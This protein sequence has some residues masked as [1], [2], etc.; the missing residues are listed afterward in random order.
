MMGYSETQKGMRCYNPDN[1]IVTISRDVT[2]VDEPETYND[3]LID[4][5]DSIVEGKHYTEPIIPTAS[6]CGVSRK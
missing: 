5:S 3:V 2:F 1:R 6:T 4:I